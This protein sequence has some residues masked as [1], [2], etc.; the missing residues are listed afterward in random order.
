MITII[1]Q[2]DIDVW[3]VREAHSLLDDFH[4]EKIMFQA[5]KGFC[6]VGHDGIHLSI[7]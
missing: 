4:E 2:G 1:A 6:L 3:P 5:K 7:E